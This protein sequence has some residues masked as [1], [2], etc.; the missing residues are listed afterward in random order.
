MD[1]INNETNTKME[2]INNSIIQRTGNIPST[3]ADFKIDIQNQINS[4][5]Q[6]RNNFE[7]KISN[8][9]NN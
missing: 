8:T 5:T 1:T 2:R 6:M 4:F 7:E 3:L 9:V